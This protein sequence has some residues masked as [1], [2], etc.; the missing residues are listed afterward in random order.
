[1]LDGV[2]GIYRRRSLIRDEDRDECA[3]MVGAAPHRAR[4]GGRSHSSLRCIAAGLTIF[5][6]EDAN[7]PAPHHQQVLFH[8]RLD[9]RDHLARTLR[10]SSTEHDANLALRAFERWGERVADHLVGDYAMVVIDEAAHRL[11]LCRD[12]MGM[13]PLYFR[14]EDDRVIF[15]SEVAQIL[16]VEGVPRRINREMVAHYL[17]DIDSPLSLTFYDGVSQ[18]EP[19]ETVTIT[20]TGVKRR[21]R[22]DEMKFER[23]RYENEEEY[24]DHLLDLLTTATRDRLRNAGR[25]AVSLSGGTD[26][27]SVT[28]LAAHELVKL[29][30][31]PSD[32]LRTYS[33][34]FEDFPDCDER[35]ISSQLNAALSLR[36]TDVSV[37]RHLPLSDYPARKPSVDD[38]YIIAYSAVVDEVFRLGK[39]DGAVTMLSGLR[40]DLVAGEPIYDFTGMLLEGKILKLLRELRL[41]AEARGRS[42]P[43]VARTLMVS[44]WLNHILHPRVLRALRQRLRDRRLRTGRLDPFPP[45][46]PHALRKEVRTENLFPQSMLPRGSDPAC[47]QRLRAILMPSQMRGMVREE[48]ECAF[49]G[50]R[51][52]DVW[53]DIRIAE[54]AVA[55]PQ[56]LW[57]TTYESKRLVRKA[58]HGLVPDRIRAQMRK[59]Y[60]MRVYDTV[61]RGT[62]RPVVVALLENSMAQ[63]AGFIDAASLYS[64]YE[65]YASGGSEPPGLWRVLCLER[66]LRNSPYL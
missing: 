58:M 29:G 45:W 17:C 30:H 53:S 38:P 6:S 5:A 26:S 24:A 35:H 4:Y 22:W 50:L 10:S 34:A 25:I 33:F 51:F 57:N 65:T 11:V 60:P 20:A 3:R 32:V 39:A 8:G 21:Q 16:E 12:P 49:A 54:F 48:R 43:A 13:R 19:G 37:R 59:I 9:D 36:G 27:T 40:G 56:R 46:M 41:H 42:V 31:E 7:Q 44:P 2:C 28:A 52:V 63:E 23:L 18:V 64:G 14:L 55:V 47:T 15:A 66:W 1:M 62:A 61:M